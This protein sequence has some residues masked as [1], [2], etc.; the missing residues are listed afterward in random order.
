MRIGGGFI[1]ATFGFNYQLVK[2]FALFA[3]VQ[4]SVWFPKT[5]SFLIDLNLGPV[6]TF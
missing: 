4:V 1:G 2:N 3:E 5:S 6:I